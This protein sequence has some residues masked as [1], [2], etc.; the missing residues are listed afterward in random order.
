MTTGKFNVLWKE[1][2]TG[3]NFA[4]DQSCFGIGSRAMLRPDDIG[5]GWLETT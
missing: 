4:D 1:L 5:V 3:S 2:K